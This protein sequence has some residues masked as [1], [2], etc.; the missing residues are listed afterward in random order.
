MEPPEISAVRA[1]TGAAVHSGWPGWQATALPRASPRGTILG[2]AEAARNTFEH[3]GETW[4][5]S[6]YPAVKPLHHPLLRRRDFFR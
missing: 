3:A 1:R 6:L 5:G 2:Q 4:L